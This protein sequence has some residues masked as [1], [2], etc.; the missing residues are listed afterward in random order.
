ME[1]NF[2]KETSIS[3]Y[4][5]TVPTLT[6]SVELSTAREDTSFAAIR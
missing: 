2:P 5:A 3:T 6:I 1:G 4:N